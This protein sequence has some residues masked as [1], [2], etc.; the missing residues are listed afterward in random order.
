MERETIPLSAIN[1]PTQAK[2]F[3]YYEKITTVNQ[4]ASY[5]AKE[6][7]SAPNL[8][9]VT[10]EKLQAELKRLGFYFKGEEPVK[11]PPE[12]LVDILHRLRRW[13][14]G[15]MIDPEALR[16]EVKDRRN[17]EGITWSL[18]Q[19]CGPLVGIP[20]NWSCYKIQLVGFY[21]ELKGA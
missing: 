18:K 19:E 9:R 8:G 15:N 14:K 4:L 13:C 17:F 16:I 2:S 11:R 1:V 3:L 6:V 5:T 20:V 10:F 21:I 12:A 7:Q